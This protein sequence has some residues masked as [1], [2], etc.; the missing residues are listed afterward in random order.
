MLLQLLLAPGY[1]AA[2][3]LP[4]LKLSRFL[5][6]NSICLS[7]VLKSHILLLNSAGVRRHHCFSCEAT[8]SFILMAHTGKVVCIR[9]YFPCSVEVLTRRRMELLGNI[10]MDGWMNSMGLRGALDDIT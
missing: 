7:I 4:K 1:H 10:T 9:I 8:I 3:P 6:E 2:A 5:T